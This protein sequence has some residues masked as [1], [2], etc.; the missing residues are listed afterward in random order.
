MMEVVARSWNASCTRLRRMKKKKKGDIPFSQEGRLQEEVPREVSLDSRAL[1]HSFL[2]RKN[3]FEER[4]GGSNVSFLLTKFLT[5]HI[6]AGNW[7]RGMILALGARGPGFESRI[8]PM[9]L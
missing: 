2:L 4:P 7:S 8:P 1:F 9:F 6:S 5:T 3:N